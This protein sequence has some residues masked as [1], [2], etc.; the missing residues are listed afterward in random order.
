M[1]MGDRIAADV[2]KECP[3][4]TW[5]KMMVDAMKIRSTPNIGGAASTRQVA[6]AMCTAIA[7]SHILNMEVA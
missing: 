6:D 2:S 1:V 7:G 5:D 4:V 3:D